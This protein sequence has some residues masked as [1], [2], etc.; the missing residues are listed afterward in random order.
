MK[1]MR[2]VKLLSVP[3]AGLLT[4]VAGPVAHADTQ[5]GIFT[6]GE[7]LLV[8]F[9]S[10]GRWVDHRA[11]IKQAD[12]EKTEM[13]VMEIRDNRTDAIKPEQRKST[14]WQGRRQDTRRY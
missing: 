1:N 9:Q 14:G 13:A 3:L 12:E 4:I 6:N 2:K 11:S 10:S 5:A 7:P 8:A